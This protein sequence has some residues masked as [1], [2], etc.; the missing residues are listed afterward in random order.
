MLS[1]Y[2]L[3]VIGGIFITL[4][5]CLVLVF[6]GKQRTYSKFLL[7]AILFCLT[8]YAMIYLLINTRIILKIPFIFGWGTPIYYLAPPLCYWYVQSMLKPDWKIKKIAL[9]HLLPSA[10]SL[11]TTVPYLLSAEKYNIMQAIVND[12]GRAPLY[13]TGLISNLFHFAFRPLQGLAYMLMI[14]PLIYRVLFEG[15]ST[16]RKKWENHNLWLFIFAVLMT[17]IYLGVG[18]CTLIAMN[19]LSDGSQ[20]FNMIKVPLIWCA[21]SFFALGAYLFFN[22]R[23]VYGTEEKNVEV[24]MSGNGLLVTRQVRKAEAI[25]TELVQHYVEVL[26][27]FVDDKTPFRRQGVSIND[28]AAETGIPARTLSYILNHHYKLRFTDFVNSYRLSF[29]KAQL[30]EGRWKDMSLEGLALEAG[31]SSRSAF[32][33]SFKKFTGQ[34][35]SQYI[36]MLEERRKTN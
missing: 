28:F 30:D 25:S 29:I 9:L 16:S 24:E 12:F 3:F 35:P 19:N 10:I 23:I 21:F 6:K 8:W 22:P 36:S 14:W 13:D 31:F 33:T 5:L 17:L 32:F 27:K 26:E 20:T 1:F 4:I 18:V 2:D 34:N 15:G 11:V 7:A